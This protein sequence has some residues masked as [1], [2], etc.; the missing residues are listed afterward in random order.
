MAPLRRIWLILFTILIIITNSN[1]QIPETCKPI[2]TFKFE[3]NPPK[4]QYL[5]F[6][7]QYNDKTCCNP[8]H[9]L[10]IFQQTRPLLRNEQVSQECKQLTMDIICS[11]CN[12]QIGTHHLNGICTV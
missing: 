9:S 5:P 3:R 12:P 2:N 10:Q 7:K 8:S 6:C 4:K 1:S 11:S